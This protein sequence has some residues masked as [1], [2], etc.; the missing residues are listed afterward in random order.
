ML[1]VRLF[2][3][4]MLLLALVLAIGDAGI[5]EDVAR[6]PI[7]GAQPFKALPEL[8]S[9]MGAAWTDWMAA[10]VGRDS[11]LTHVLSSLPAAPSLA[12]G[13]LLLLIATWPG[14]RRSR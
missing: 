14:R 9:R 11:A 5:I 10:T 4:L 13:A 1:A 6:L 12:I 8:V 3:V 7:G 2:A